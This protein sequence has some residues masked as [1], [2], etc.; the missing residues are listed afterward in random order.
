MRRRAQI[1]LSFFLTM[2]LL[3]GVYA[4]RGIEPFGANTLLF[5]DMGGQYLN[6]MAGY[7]ELFGRGL[8]YTWHK[9]LGGEALS[10]NA[11]YLFSP[12]NLL[13]L[14]FPAA[15]LSLA[16]VCITLLKTGAAGLTMGLFLRSLGSRGPVALALAA[17]YALSGYMAGFAQNLMWLDG[18]IA[19]PPPFRRAALAVSGGPL[20][21]AAHL[22]LH[23]LDALPLFR[24]LL[25]AALAGAGPRPAAPAHCGALLR[26]QRPG[27]GPGRLGAAA[28]RACPG[29]GQGK[30]CNGVGL[31]RKL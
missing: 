3:A 20:C 19:A 21:R 16:V 2:L 30:L 24:P 17:A 4:A 6:F 12:F 26:R 15:K 31:C 27:R 22:L 13:L 11:Y 23:W 9:A 25:F 28:L 18:V 29:A 5:G 7:K 14:L 10:L 8:F 1:L